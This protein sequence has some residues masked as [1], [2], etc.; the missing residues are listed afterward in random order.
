[1]NFAERFWKAINAVSSTSASL[2]MG[3]RPYG[4]PTCES[5]ASIDARRWHREG[6]LHPGQCFPYSWT[7]A[8]EPAGSI[9]VRTEAEAVVLMFRS[10]TSEDIEWRSVACRLPGRRAV[11]AADAL[12]FAVPST[13]AV[14]I[15]GAA[16]RCSTQRASY[17]RPM[18]FV[19][20]VRRAKL[21]PARD[22]L[23][24]R[25]SSSCRHARS[26]VSRGFPRATAG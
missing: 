11:L 19:I 15:A 4:G 16:L 3:R 7:R 6:R 20:S 24:L 9:K 5:C 25:W 2:L 22:R 12:G 1:L 26:A 23:P 17:S 8:G 18:L 10:R 14:A 13:P 21:G